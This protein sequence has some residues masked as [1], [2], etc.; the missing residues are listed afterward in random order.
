MDE[1]YNAKFLSIS[2]IQVEKIQAVLK[3]LGFLVDSLNLKSREYVGEKGI[4]DIENEITA[5]LNTFVKKP[6]KD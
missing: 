2:K 4:F 1:K 3:S 5:F 6:V